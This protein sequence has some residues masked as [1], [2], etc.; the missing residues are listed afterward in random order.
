LGVMKFTAKK[1]KINKNKM[2]QKIT[3]KNRKYE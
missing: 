1:I 3:Q 2:F